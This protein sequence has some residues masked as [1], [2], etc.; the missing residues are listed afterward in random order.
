VLAGAFFTKADT[1]AKFKLLQTMGATPGFVPPD[2][3]A[4]C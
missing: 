4:Y 3:A 2:T 1:L